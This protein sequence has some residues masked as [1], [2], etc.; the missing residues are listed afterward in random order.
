MTATRDCQMATQA[1]ALQLYAPGPEVPDI[2]SDL[3]A[4]PDWMREARHAAWAQY[5]EL[6]LPPLAA[7]AWRRTPIARYPWDS[8][9]VGI[10]G[11]EFQSL[12][13]LPLCWHNNLSPEDQ[14]SGTLVHCNGVRAY[15]AMRREDAANGVVFEGLH[16]ALNTHGEIV[17]RYWQNGVSSSDFDKFTALNAALWHGGT[18]LYVPEGVRV[19]RPLQ[20]LVSCDGE[21]GSTLHHTLII[22]EK[23][24]HV[25][26]IQDRVSQERQSELNVEV[27][28]IYAEAGA[29]VRYISLQHWGMQRYSVSVQ[30][31]QLKQDAN[32]VWLNGALGGKMS[33]DFLRT[34]LVEEG[35]R[36]LMHGFTY[37]VDHQHID[38]STYQ[39]HCAP[40]THSDLLFRTVLRDAART[41][42]YGMI[43]AER[44]AVAMEGY[45]AN[46]NLLLSR[47]EGAER[48]HAHAIPGLEILCDDVKCSHGATLSRINPEQLFYLQGRGLPREEAERLIVQGF[49]RSIIERIPLALMRENLEAEIAERFWM[50][51]APATPL[52]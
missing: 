52:G 6:P 22:A 38:Q 31:V 20:S 11:P 45:Q 35:A 47:E 10:S 32:L 9:R 28:E 16:R 37:A 1:G 49:M 14:V 12:S 36:A 23:G 25:T 19:S 46:H 33:K 34:T 48:A 7:E 4:E 3:Y 43:R 26:L 41:V 29:W 50:K 17:R 21:S 27:V 51:A 44:E 15:A 18:F 40:N 24:S 30:N 2:L 42:F 39:H 8:L 5:R 13:D